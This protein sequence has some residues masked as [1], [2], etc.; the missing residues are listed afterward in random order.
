MSDLKEKTKAKPEEIGGFL[1]YLVGTRT[2]EFLNDEKQMAKMGLTETDKDYLNTELVI[3][4]MFIMIKQFTRWESNEEIYTRALDRMHF[5]L[6]HQL[7]EYSDYDSD[8][9]EELHDHIFERYS[10]YG[11]IIQANRDNNWPEELGK[12]VLY[13]LNDEIDY[14]DRAISVITDYITKF[15]KSIPFLLNTI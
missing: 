5:L 13:N 3:L 6:F 15:Y 7:K 11:D 4:N 10:E 9:I 2:D 12:A 1:Y 14:D 8:D